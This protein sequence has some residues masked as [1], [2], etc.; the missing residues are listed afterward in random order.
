MLII[1]QDLNGNEI[2]AFGNDDDGGDSPAAPRMGDTVVL[3][4]EDE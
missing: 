4:H 2:A 1:F 3:M